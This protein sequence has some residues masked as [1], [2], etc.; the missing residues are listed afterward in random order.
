MSQPMPRVNL[1]GAVDLSSLAGPPAGQ[2]QA[3]AP[4]GAPAGAV[5]GAVVTD[6]SEATFGQTVQLSTQV[7]VLLLLG[8]ARSGATAELDAVL[9]KLAR[10]YGGRFQLARVDGDANPQI[11][12]ALQVQA[13][14][15]V[16]AL[17]AGQP[18]PLFQGAY[19]EDQVRQVL[20][21]VL[22]V[23]AQNG[24]TGVLED[25]G[26]DVAEAPEEPPLPPLHAE[27]LAA[28]ERGDLDGAEAAYTQALNENPRDADAKAALLQV[29]LIRRVEQHDPDEVL[30]RAAAAGPADVAAQLAA[31]DV[32]AT[33]GQFGAAFDRLLAV[34]RATAGDDRE[35]ARLRLI[36]LFDI[37]GPTPE[38]QSARRQLASALY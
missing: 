12:A 22:R 9:E 29:Q 10:E 1:H 25:T 28:I 31:A 32:E 24:V 36:E 26:D 16:V 19:P 13:V 7:P 37:A 5:P 2:Q 20:D 34:V 23:A 30:R 8:S 38:V 3:A 35:Q 14:P 18:L 21:E 27:A 4:G 33:T 11:A 6:V 17:V 15:T